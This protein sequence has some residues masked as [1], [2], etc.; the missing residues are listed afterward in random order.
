[1][2]KRKWRLPLPLL[3]VIIVLLLAVW[4][5][6]SACRSVHPARKPIG[7]AFPKVTGT[8]LAGAEV[9]L[10]PLGR[11]SV[12]LIGY[13]QNAQFDADRWLVGL[14]QVPLDASILEVP[15]LP[16]LFAGAASGFIDSGM[17]SGIPSEDWSSVVTVY[18]AAAEQITRFTGSEKTRNMRVLAL[19]SDG[20]VRWMHDRGFS[21]SK[22][23]E[24]AELVRSMERPR[25]DIQ[26][27]Q[28]AF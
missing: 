7:E 12:L 21:A 16:G 1:M 11:P 18:G 3:L 19:D 10:P 20:R 2:T 22:L 23:L 14:L 17:R 25:G 28:P 15:T 9:E 24:L 4:G 26:A 6:L 27:D 13:E 5:P 8:S